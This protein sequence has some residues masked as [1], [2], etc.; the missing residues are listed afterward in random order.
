MK[1]KS[2]PPWGTGKIKVKGKKMHKI[3]GVGNQKKR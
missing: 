1:G 2:G 3:R